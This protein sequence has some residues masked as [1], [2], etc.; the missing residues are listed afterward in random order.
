MNNFDALENLKNA[1]ESFNFFR[2]N[3]ID[4]FKR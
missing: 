4:Y 3:N 1:Y 2:N